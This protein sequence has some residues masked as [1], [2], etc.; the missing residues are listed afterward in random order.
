MKGNRVKKSVRISALSEVKQKQLCE[1]RNWKFGDL[2]D[3]LIDE[4]FERD[5][6]RK[7]IDFHLLRDSSKFDDI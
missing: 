1:K 5:R 6:P 4:A 2:I 3:S 7:A